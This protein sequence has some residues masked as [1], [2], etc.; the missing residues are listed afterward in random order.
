MEYNIKWEGY[1]ESESTWEKEEDCQCDE[2]IEQYERTVAERKSN[3][4][5]QPA[6]R[7]KESTS[8]AVLQATISPSK[9]YTNIKQQIIY[10]YAFTHVNIHTD[11]HFLTYNKWHYIYITHTTNDNIGSPIH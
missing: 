11:I 10:I 9:I 4:K 5:E 7:L 1:D 2:L 8:D 3:L 6:K